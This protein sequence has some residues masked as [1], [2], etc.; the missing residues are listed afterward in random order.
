MLERDVDVRVSA[1]VHGNDGHR[2][3][4]LLTNDTI[5]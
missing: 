5:K 2:G 3:Y 4:K 1:W